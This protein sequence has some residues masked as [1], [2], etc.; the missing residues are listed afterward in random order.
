YINYKL[1]L[2]EAYTLGLDTVTSYKKELAKYREQ[3][4]QPYL[5]DRT[6]TDALVKEAYNRMLQE[7]NASH[8]LVRLNPKASPEDTLRAYTKIMTARKKVMSGV[9]FTD[10][11]KEYSEDPSAQKNGG[12]L[13]YFTVFGMVYPF[14]NAA[15]ST[16]IGDVSM[17]FKTSFGYHILRVNDK[18][19]ARGE[20]EVAHIMVKNNAKDTAQAERQINEIYTKLNQGDTFDFLAQQ[21][22]DDKASAPKGGRLPKFSANKMIASFSDVAFAMKNKNNIS[23]PFQTPYGWH[24]IRLIKKYPVKGFEEV[25]EDLLKKI[26]NS[27]RASAIGNSVA[28][29]LKKKYHIKYDELLKQAFLKNDSELLK[30]NEEKFIFVIHSKEIRLKELIDHSRK[31]RNK[32]MIQSYNDFLNQEVIMYYKEHLE[33]TNKDFAIT[34]QEYKD[35]LLLFDLL[36]EKI[37]KRAEKDTVA[38]QKFFKM[39]RQNYMHNKRGDLIIATCTNEE[40][41][42]KVKKYLEENK[43][44]DEIKNLVNESPTIHVLFSSGLVDA[45]NKKLPK[46]FEIKKGVSKI[47]KQDD[48]HYIIVKVNEI[49]EPSQKK[50]SEARGLVINDFQEYIEKKWIED[51]RGRHVV[52][53]KKQTLKKLIKEYSN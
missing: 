9:K 42:E 14:E 10:V 1:K 3:L 33:S 40:K 17:P 39:N 30:K 51:L 28:H 21:Y 27:P 41:A 8:I 37:W 31:Q 38:L 4:I 50:L 16:N 13:G 5:R 6:I 24:V 44:I 29:K 7:V 11:A 22:S 18:R 26:E 19:A 20:V 47:F 52:K 35:G 12:D 53:V 34:M 48:N 23:K 36:Q 2:K 32:S 45:N 25:K 49:F 15:Y 43:T 46:E